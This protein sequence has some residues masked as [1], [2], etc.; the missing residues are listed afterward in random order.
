M[1][2]LSTQNQE[3]LIRPATDHDTDAVAGCVTA[4]FTHYIDSIGKPPG[5]MLADFPSIIADGKVWVAEIDTRVVGV[6]VQYETETGFYIDTVAVMPAHQGTGI[7]R[8]LLQFAEGEARRRGYKS[9]YLCTNEKMTENQVY[10]PKM[11]YC[12]YDRKNE[13]GYDRIFYRKPLP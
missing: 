7:G 12:E 10:Y 4:A 9:I 5:P 2:N 13:H 3:P 1:A 8:A 11:G 6:L